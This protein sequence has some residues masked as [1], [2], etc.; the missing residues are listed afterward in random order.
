MAYKVQNI[1][2]YKINFGE[3]K[4]FKTPVNFHRIPIT[5]NGKP[6][7]IQIKCIA[8]LFEN[9]DATK[10]ICGYSLRMQDIGED[11]ISKIEDI[12]KV[13]KNEVRNIEPEIRKRMLDTEELSI[14]YSKEGF[15]PSIFEKRFF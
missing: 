10:M 8:T 12:I 5:Y 1:E 11:F 6:L 4:E 9:K 2:V 15:E 14:L 7:I 13:I 3:I